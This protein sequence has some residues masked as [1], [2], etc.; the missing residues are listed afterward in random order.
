[1]VGLDRSTYYGIKFHKPCNREIRH[2]LL[3]DAIADI[4]ASSRGTYGMLR[5]K[6]A[7]EIEQ[8]LIVNKKLVWKIMASWA[9]RAS[10]DRGRA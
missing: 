3:E 10:R 2:V 9:F 6:A 7:L 4:H 8:G 1:M 5:V